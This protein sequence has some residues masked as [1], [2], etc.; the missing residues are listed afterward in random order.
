[1]LKFNLQLNDEKT[2]VK[3]AS[4]V[5]MDR[6]RYELISVAIAK[7]DALQQARDIRKVNELAHY[8]A[9][10]LGNAHPI[11]WTC[12][13]LVRLSCQA[14]NFTLLLTTLLR[15]GRDFP[16]TIN[17]VAVFIINNKASCSTPLRRKRIDE[18]VKAIFA[19][20]SHNSHDFEVTWALVI[21]G[22]LQI[23]VSIKDFGDYSNSIC[24]V[25]FAILGLLSDK[26]LLAEPLSSFGWRPQVKR[27]GVNGHHW[28][29]F[30]ESVLRGWTKDKQMIS[31][32]K[33]DPLMGEL[34]KAG[35]TF[36]DDTIFGDVL[37]DLERRRMRKRRYPALFGDASFGLAS[38]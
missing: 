15:L 14:K 6:W 18:W 21:C 19:S 4:E 33:S 7:S 10:T 16:S 3:K 24:S 23:T 38:I 2:G 26:N 31:S 27:S 22:A 36:L 30:Y 25:A 28:I 35:V 20:H 12:Q 29:M 9:F 8:H 37:V 5:F 1:L 17:L 13:K 32:V 11:K 34:L